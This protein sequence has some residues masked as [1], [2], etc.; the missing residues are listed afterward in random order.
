MPEINYCWY[1]PTF[2]TLYM[3]ATLN[4][5]CC[6]YIL[7][8]QSAFL[9][10][11]VFSH[12]CTMYNY[13]NNCDSFSLVPRHLKNWRRAPGIHRLRMRVKIRYISRIIYQDM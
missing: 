12:L 8:V 7:R 6:I 5:H 2:C 10:H 1:K 4:Y 11:T 13:R 3:R 9:K